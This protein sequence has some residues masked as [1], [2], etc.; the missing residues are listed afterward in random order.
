MIV[1]VCL[2]IK[3]EFD[4]ERH[5]VTIHDDVRDSLVAALGVTQGLTSHEIED[6][7]ARIGGDDML[8]LDSKTAEF[9]LVAAE[10]VAG[11]RLP[12]PAD[13]G[14]DQYATLGILIDVVMKEI[15]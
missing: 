5:Q 14:E 10:K 9:L 11:R 6:E 4:A 15:Q 3:R 12:C 13:L 1:L 7:L 2:N 8:E